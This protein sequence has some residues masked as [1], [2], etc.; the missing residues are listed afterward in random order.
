MAKR[1]VG[2]IRRGILNLRLRVPA[3]VKLTAGETSTLIDVWKDD[4]KILTGN[5]TQLETA[6]QAITRNISRIPDSLQEVT[7][8]RTE[9]ARFFKITKD[10]IKKREWARRLVVAER[11]RVAIKGSQKRMIV[12][13]DRI[14]TLVSDAVLEKRALDT[15]I[16]EAEAYAKMGTGLKLVGESLIDARFKV[17]ANEIHFRDLELGIEDLDKTIKAVGDDSIMAEAKSIL[18]GGKKG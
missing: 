7:Q 16:A 14:K 10:P 15:R 13:Q 1:K 4:Q 5:H 2:T 17:K 12:M 18:S 9:A 6:N 3:G 11:A 8:A